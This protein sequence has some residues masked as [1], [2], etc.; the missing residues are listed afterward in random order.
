MVTRL[1]WMAHKLV[2][3]KRPTKYASLAS[4]NAMTAELWKR[5]VADVHQTRDGHLLI[6][7]SEGSAK[8]VA[9][10]FAEGKVGEKV[11]ALMGERRTTLMMTNIEAALGEAEIKA[12]IVEQTRAAAE[13]IEVRDLRG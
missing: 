7:L 9:K 11:E 1:A 8:D 3:S 10:I 12:A 13:D 6:S 5:K 4:C 2:S